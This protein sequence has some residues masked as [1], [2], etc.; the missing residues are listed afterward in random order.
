M[1]VGAMVQM[2]AYS[3][4]SAIADGVEGSAAAIVCVRGTDITAIIRFAAAD[5]PLSPGRSEWTGLLLVLCI[6]RRV[7]ADVALR[8][9]NLQVVNTFSD[10]PARYEYNWLR[11]NDRAMA[12]L[13]WELSAE[14]ERR[15]L[16]TLTVLHQLGHPEKRATPAQYDTHD[17]YNVRVNAATHRIKSDMP[18]YISFRRM[19]RQ[20]TQLWYEPLE[21]ENVGHGTAH[22]A[23]GDSYRNIAK[24]AQAPGC[25]TRTVSSSRS[26]FEGQRAERRP[27]AAR[28]SPL[29]SCTSIWPLMLGR[30]CG[31]E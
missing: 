19:S 7:R 17:R 4:G 15:G 5:R 30:P 6:V 12:S 8:L 28:R 2:L 25:G 18:L 21:E 23:T 10:G 3:D 9:G 16:G 14:R 20:H 31:A 29:S 13:A 11:R 26:S 1:A 22:E 27:S 24:A